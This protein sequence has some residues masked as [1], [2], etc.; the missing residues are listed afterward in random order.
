[1]D[2]NKIFVTTIIVIY[3]RKIDL[4]YN[5]LSRF[6]EVKYPKCSEHSS[7]KNDL[8]G[9]WKTLAPAIAI[10]QFINYTN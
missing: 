6:I 4:L 9:K 1:M 10:N 2:I 8:Y 3:R 7:V 5:F